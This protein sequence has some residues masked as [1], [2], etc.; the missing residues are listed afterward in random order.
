MI[1]VC[2]E[3]DAACPHGMSCPYAFDRYTCWRP[4]PGTEGAPVTPAQP[5]RSK[6]SRTAE[7][8]A[9]KQPPNPSPTLT[10][11]ET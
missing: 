2:P 9:P 5:L 3:R 7:R 1:R 8:E 4:Q 11:S 10:G 6:A